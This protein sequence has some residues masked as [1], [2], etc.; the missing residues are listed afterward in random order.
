MWWN[1]Q[2]SDKWRYQL[3]SVCKIENKSADWR[4]K[5]QIKWQWILFSFAIATVVFTFIVARAPAVLMF[6]F[7]FVIIESF[8]LI[9][10]WVI[11]FLL[12]PI[13]C[14]ETLNFYPAEYVISYSTM[15]LR[16]VCDSRAKQWKSNVTMSYTYR[17]IAHSPYWI[18]M[19]DIATALSSHWT[20]LYKLERTDLFQIIYVKFMKLSWT[21][22]KQLKVFANGD[23]DDQSPRT[24]FRLYSVFRFPKD[25][26]I[27]C[28][29]KYQ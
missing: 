25:K 1:S 19:N 22:Q 16:C 21:I 26:N 7:L 14:F 29:T 9:L 6:S 2:Y 15:R 17:P 20:W 11:R 24:F 8:L 28:T 12:S 5:L 10:Y 23:D 13:F 4:K 18:P 27:D 3:P